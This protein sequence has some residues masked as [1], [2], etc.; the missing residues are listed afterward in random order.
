MC[1]YALHLLR[2]RRVE[3]NRTKE[4]Q[5]A[6]CEMTTFAHLQDNQYEVCYGIIK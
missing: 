2:R 1:L 5:R 6:N 4:K 3:L